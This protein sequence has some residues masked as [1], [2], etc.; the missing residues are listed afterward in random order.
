[1]FAILSSQKLSLLSIEASFY[2]PDAFLS[3][4]E[5]SLLSIEVSLSPPKLLFYPLKLAHLPKKFLF[6]FFGPKAR[7]GY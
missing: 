4:L 2:S 1:M 3:S 6:L 7:V 5:V